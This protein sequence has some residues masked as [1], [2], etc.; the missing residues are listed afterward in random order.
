MEPPILLFRLTL[1]TALVGVVELLVALQAGTAQE[2][3]L[4][5]A[6]GLLGLFGLVDQMQSLDVLLH[7]ELVLRL[8]T[9]ARQS[10]LEAA[11]AVQ[12]GALALLHDV[13][14]DILQCLQHRL[15]VRDGARALLLDA[16][17]YHVGRHG[18]AD[19]GLGIPLTALARVRTLVLYQ[20]VIN[21]TLCVF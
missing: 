20:S 17:G 11:D 1:A 21:H 16:V 14:D 2:L 7:L 4:V 5:L 19:H 18:L 8:G 15:H 10:C 6:R 9:A 3:L 12:T 13:G